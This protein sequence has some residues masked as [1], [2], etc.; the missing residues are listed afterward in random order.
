MLTTVD[1]SRGS[2]SIAQVNASLLR[3]NPVIVCSGTNLR[4]VA[5]EVSTLLAGN[6][7]GPQRSGHWS[8]GGYEGSA[9]ANSQNAV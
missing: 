9:S 4:L 5:P 7:L 2:L 3:K 8:D 1:R 6:D